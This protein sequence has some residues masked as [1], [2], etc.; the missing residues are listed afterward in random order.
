MDQHLLSIILLTPLAGLL[1]MLFIP[2]S[3]KGAIRIWANLAA[4]AETLRRMGQELEWVTVS[5][6]ADRWRKNHQRRSA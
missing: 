2:G 1:V 4:L 5:E 6:A 3:S